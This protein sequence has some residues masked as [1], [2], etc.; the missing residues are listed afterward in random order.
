[1]IETLASTGPILSA[2]FSCCELTSGIDPMADPVRP[3]PS[4]ECPVV[5]VSGQSYVRAYVLSVLQSVD[6]D[7]ARMHKKGFCYACTRST[8]LLSRS[9]Q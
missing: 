4:G 9:W 5:A 6:A 8:S 2:L 7:S 3:T 1:M